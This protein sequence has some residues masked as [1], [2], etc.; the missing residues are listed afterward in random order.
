MMSGSFGT[1]NDQARAQRHGIPQTTLARRQASTTTSSLE[2]D[3]QL[4]EKV[5]E[6]RGD[7]ENGTQPSPDQT[8]LYL[9]YGS[10]MAS[11]TFL[12]NRGI[13]PISLI[14]VYVPELRLTF[15]LAGVPYREPCFASTRYRLGHGPSGNTDNYNYAMVEKDMSEKAPLWRQGYDDERNAWHKPLIG[16]VY[17]ITLKDYA[18]IIATEAGGRGYNDGIVTC[19]PFP[20]TYN[21]VDDVPEHPSTRP[22]KAH[23]LLSL[24]ADEDDYAAHGDI[25]LL[26]NP[27]IRPDPSYAQPSK[28][29]ID[30]LNAGAVE[31]NLPFSYRAY[32]SQIPSYRVTT[33]RQRIGKSIFLSI[34]GPLF[35]FVTYLT[36]KYAKPDGY[37]PR[38]LTVI[39]TIVHG[40]MWAC[41][42]LIFARVFG[43][44]E[45]TIGD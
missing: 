7:L 12:G 1:T 44:G 20:E 8:V 35:V 29:Y 30:I 22:F 27:R 32:L 42:D 18:W 9:A 16:V 40:C 38:W 36:M 34:W 11:K 19:Y 21:P 26:R 37:S 6:L 10:N 5:L 17:E 15:D 13:K 3:D 43:D 2:L 41:Y 24:I 23:C 28:R 4:S 45:R 39:S 14:N 33:T 25:S 31:N